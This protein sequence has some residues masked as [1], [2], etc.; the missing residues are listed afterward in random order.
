MWFRDRD[1]E[2]IGAVPDVV[3]GEFSTTCLCKHPISSHFPHTGT[4]RHYGCHCY[5]FFPKNAVPRRQN[6]IDGLWKAVLPS[7]EQP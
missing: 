4:C 7:E 2:T 1:K 3:K 6:A 5:W